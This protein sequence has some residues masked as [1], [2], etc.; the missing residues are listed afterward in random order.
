[1][2]NLIK[3]YIFPMLENLI[4]YNISKLCRNLF[5]SKQYPE[6]Y[7]KTKFTSC[8]MVEIKLL[9]ELLGLN[10]Y[11]SFVDLI[12]ISLYKQSYDIEYYKKHTKLCNVKMNVQNLKVNKQT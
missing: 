8:Y 3:K 7:E 6:P 10:I 12:P 5:R 1:M 4:H 11:I 9:G 2:Y